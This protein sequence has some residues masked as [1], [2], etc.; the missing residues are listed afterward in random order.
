M[1]QL[2]DE[3]DLDE[4]IPLFPISD[5]EAVYTDFD[6]FGTPLRLHRLFAH[7]ASDDELRVATSKAL[8]LR[9][10]KMFRGERYWDAN[11][12]RNFTRYKRLKRF[13]GDLEWKHATMRFFV[14]S[15][16]LPYL[17]FDASRLCPTA[18]I[19]YSSC[20]TVDGPSQRR[21]FWEGKEVLNCK[22]PPNIAR[23]F[24]EIL[25]ANMG[26]V[27]NELTLANFIDK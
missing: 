8:I 21:Y 7:A 13:S 11:Q 14:R 27:P 5:Q 23:K 22:C 25:K 15:P 4:D 12:R 10:E 16:D 26:V 9:F 19:V 1:I 17:G 2:A 24:V 18:P 20:C 3:L 6:Q